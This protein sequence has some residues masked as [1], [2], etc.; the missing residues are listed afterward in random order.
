[1]ASTCC[2]LDAQFLT[3]TYSEAVA[4]YPE[5]IQDGVIPCGLHIVIDVPNVQFEHLLVRGKLTFNEGTD[6]KVRAKG[7]L[8]CG[9]LSAGTSQAPRQSKLTF[10]LYGSKA[11]NWKGSSH[12]QKVLLLLDRISG[13]VH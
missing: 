13:E 8:V 10:E 3:L 2:P 4:S 9:E 7:V 5:I 6:I 12:N 1:M 11:L